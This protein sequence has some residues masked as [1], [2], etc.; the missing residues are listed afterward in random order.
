MRERGRGVELLYSSY[1][2]S[3]PFFPSLYPP[4]L[5][6]YGEEKKEYERIYQ[7]SPYSLLERER[8]CSYPP[9][10][11]RKKQKEREEEGINL[12]IN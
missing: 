6:L 12:L 1:Y 4:I 5:P 3:V 8:T 10:G 11:D 7:F 2:F 9:T